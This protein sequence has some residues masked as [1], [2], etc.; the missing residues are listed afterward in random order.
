MTGRSK[1]INIHDAHV[2]RMYKCPT[3]QRWL[4]P[5]NPGMT[6]A[7]PLALRVSWLLVPCISLGYDYWKKIQMK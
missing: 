5:G 7:E 4:S 1:S 3:K 2:L 6:L